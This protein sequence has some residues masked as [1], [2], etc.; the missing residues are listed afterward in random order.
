MQ[1]YFIL[2]DQHEPVEVD[3][4]TSSKWDANIADTMVDEYSRVWTIFLGTTVDRDPP[5]QPYFVHYVIEPGSLYRT[6]NTYGYHEAVARHGRIVE[7][8][9]KRV[10]RRR[11]RAAAVSAS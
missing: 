2:N 5:A 6:V 11:Q 8:M 10:E 1:H 9:K 7:W 4:E 3:L